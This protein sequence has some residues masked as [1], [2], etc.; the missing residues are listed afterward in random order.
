MVSVNRF[1]ADG[2]IDGGS[3]GKKITDK[4]KID[5]NTLCIKDSMDELCYAVWIKGRDVQL[6][7]EDT[8][9]I[10]SGSIK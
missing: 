6:V 5:K 7:Y 3:M 9:V 1:K 4:W 2:T 10:L 8:D